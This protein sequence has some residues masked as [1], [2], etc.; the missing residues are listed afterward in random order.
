MSESGQVAD[1]S[2]GR[3]VRLFEFLGRTQQLRNLPPRT[4]D[5]YRSVLWLDELPGHPAVTAAHRGEPGP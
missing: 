2:V 5:G 3:A 4:V 1:P